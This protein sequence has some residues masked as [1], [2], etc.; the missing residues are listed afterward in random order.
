MDSEKILSMIYSLFMVLAWKNR[1]I[2]TVEHVPI[3]WLTRDRY[4]PECFSRGPRTFYNQDDVL[5]IFFPPRPAWGSEVYPAPVLAEGARSSNF[6]DRCHSRSYCAIRSSLPRKS[7]SQATSRASWL[8]NHRKPSWVSGRAMAQ[9][10]RVAEDVWLV[11]CLKS[12]LACFWGLDR[13]SYI[14]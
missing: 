9:V 14:P 3:K 7:S 2:L 1:F 8:P 13:G 11:L 6:L 10:Y 4:K 12:F 5:F